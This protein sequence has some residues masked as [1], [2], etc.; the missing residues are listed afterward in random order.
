L[1]VLREDDRVR[2]GDHGEVIFHPI[3]AARGS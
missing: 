3:A 2:P 1:G